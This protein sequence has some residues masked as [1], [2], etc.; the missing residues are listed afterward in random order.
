MLHRRVHAVDFDAFVGRFSSV[1]AI[2]DVHEMSSIR[3]HRTVETGGKQLLEY[4]VHWKGYGANDDTW[5]PESN[6]EQYGAER[7]LKQYKSKTGLMKVDA[8][9]CDAFTPSFR[10]R[11]FF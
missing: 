9:V 5:E 11:V 4:R 7:M 3:R 8:M 2:E 6:L 10:D 1:A